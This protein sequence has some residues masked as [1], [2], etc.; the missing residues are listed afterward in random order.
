MEIPACAPSDDVMC[1]ACSHD[2]LHV[3]NVVAEDN[4]LEYSHNYAKDICQ[5]LRDLEVGRS[6][7]ELRGHLLTH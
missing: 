7:S 5:Y 3:E 6:R 4:D 2:L 1:Q